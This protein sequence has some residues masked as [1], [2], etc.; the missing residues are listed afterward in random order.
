MWFLVIVG[1]WI[2]YIGPGRDWLTGFKDNYDN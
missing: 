1:I 2:W